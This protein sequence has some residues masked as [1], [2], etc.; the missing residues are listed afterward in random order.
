MS[1]VAKKLERYK[2]IIYDL[3]CASYEMHMYIVVLSPSFKSIRRYNLRLL[4]LVGLPGV[5]INSPPS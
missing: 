2:K 3:L 4:N 1:V 5:K